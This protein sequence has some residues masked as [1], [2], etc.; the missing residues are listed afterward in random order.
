MQVSASEGH[1]L[2]APSYDSGSNPLLALE[3]RVMEA[4]L[5]PLR[6]ATA[7]D[8]ACGTGR[9][10][11]RFEQSGINVFGVDACEPMLAQALKHKCLWGRLALGDAERLPFRSSV[12]DL[13]L[14]SLALGYFRDLARVF[15]EFVRVSKCGA[16]I[17]VSDLHPAAGKAGWERSFRAGE[18]RYEIA[19][20][21]RSIEHVRSAASAA[22]LHLKALQSVRFDKPEY[23]IFKRTKKEEVFESV[24]QIPALFLG[25]W[26]KPC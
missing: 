11:L 13:V 22:G 18:H 8:V 26:E 1:R 23:A 14:C 20:F 5:D 10:L 15:D 16:T 6:P 7:I 2:W 24:K 9:W 17:A 3:S 4:R 25:I 19:Y 12:A 21:V